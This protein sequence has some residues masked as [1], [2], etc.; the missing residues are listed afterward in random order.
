MEVIEAI[1]S[2]RSIRSFKPDP[3][4]K[5]VLEELL[6]TCR[7]APSGS[8]TQPWEIAVLGGEV[9]E[10]YKD[11]LLKKVK[12][13]WDTS[14]LSFKNINSDI[15]YPELFE[16]YSQ[17]STD[18]RTRIDSHQFPPGTKEL[19][20]KRHAYLLYGAS[21]YGA[22][23]A[24]ILYTEKALCP[25]AIFDMGLIAQSITLA[26]ISYGLGTCIQAMAVNW[27]AL[28][29][30]LLG[31]PESKLIVVAIAIGYADTEHLVNT[32]ERTRVPLDTFT[33]WHGIP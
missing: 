17:R 22:P 8:N 2:R 28:L 4:P 26:A 6:D 24:L 9:I 1:R 31:I 30:E 10:E 5:K 23:N 7:W 16:P 19:D 11:R 32:F 3:I 29:R 15:P 25:K 18:V 20:E 33:H 21:F 27:P 13:E 14:T 12:A